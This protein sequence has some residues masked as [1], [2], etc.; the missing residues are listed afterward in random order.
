MVAHDAGPG[1][2]DVRRALTAG[3]S[4]SGGLG[5][6]LT[7]VRRLMDEF[8]IDSDVGVGTTVTVTKWR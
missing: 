5:L 1:I 2:P 3:H 4:T 8:G 6:G 7:E